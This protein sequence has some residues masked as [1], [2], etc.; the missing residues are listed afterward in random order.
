MP[1]REA[2]APTLTPAFVLGHA[3]QT[4]VND[5]R[6][7]PEALRAKAGLTLQD[8]FYSEISRMQQVLCLSY[9]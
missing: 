9:A 8:V 4:I 5:L 2:G 6:Q 1:L 7:A 3:M